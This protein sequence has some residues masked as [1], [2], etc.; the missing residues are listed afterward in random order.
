MRNP[1]IAIVHTVSGPVPCCDEH[2]RQLRGLYQFLGGHVGITPAIN[3]EE[4][5][6]CANEAASQAAE[7]RKS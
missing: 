6:N 2:A 5:S 1:A 7:E 3:G 4:C